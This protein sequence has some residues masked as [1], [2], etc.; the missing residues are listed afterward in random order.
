MMDK[1]NDKYLLGR[2]NMQPLEANEAEMDNKYP[3]LETSLHNLRGCSKVIFKST[4][5][6]EDFEVL[7][8]KPIRKEQFWL[9]YYQKIPLDGVIS[10]KSQNSQKY[11]IQ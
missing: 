10:L 2:T 7:A 4:F 9:K 3:S 8:F 6:F 11:K 1:T 5:E